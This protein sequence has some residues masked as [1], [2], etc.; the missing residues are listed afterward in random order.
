[1][2]AA[3]TP[4]ARAVLRRITE[5]GR[6]STYDAVQQHFAAHPSTPI[7]L[8]R[9]GGAL[10]SFHAVQRRIGPTDADRLLQRDEQARIYRI[11]PALVDGLNRVYPLADARPDLLRPEPVGPDS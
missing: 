8:S 1:M 6:T 10:T 2:V 11:D 5:L 4:G 3:L 7:P 9:I